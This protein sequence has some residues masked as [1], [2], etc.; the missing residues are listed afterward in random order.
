MG[1]SKIYCLKGGFREWVKSGFPVEEK[2]TI[3]KEC[4]TCHSEVTPAI[5]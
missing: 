1:Y 4:V 2:W 3:R 5:V